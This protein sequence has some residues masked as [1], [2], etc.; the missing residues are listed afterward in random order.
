MEMTVWDLYF[1]GL[2][3]MTLHPG[4]NREGTVKP[5]IEDCAE[6]ADQMITERNKR[7]QD[8]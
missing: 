5:T 1:A 6:T 7:C 3:A 8:M 2:V 4:F